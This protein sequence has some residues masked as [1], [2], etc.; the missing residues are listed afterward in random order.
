MNRRVA[1]GAVCFSLVVGLT[2]CA[3][4]TN[5]TP[6]PTGTAAFV[7]S[8]ES[9]KLKAVAY[10]KVPGLIQLGELICLNLQRDVSLTKILRDVTYLNGTDDKSGLTVGER[11]QFA[12]A[13]VAA[14][15][16]HLCPDQTSKIKK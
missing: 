7:A 10:I 13:A 16:A 8:V 12:I 11:S 14:S 3:K 15:V 9:T 4:S 1:I 5:A 6:Q 2:G